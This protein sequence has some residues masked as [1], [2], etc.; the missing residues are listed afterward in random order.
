[1]TPVNI[2]DGSLI[3]NTLFKGEC[4]LRKLGRP[5]RFGSFSLP[6]RKGDCADGHKQ[7]HVKRPLAKMRLNI[8]VNVFFHFRVF[9]GVH[10]WIFTCSLRKIFAALQRRFKSC[11]LVLADYTHSADNVFKENGRKAS[12]GSAENA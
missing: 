4:S 12:E 2:L 3:R 7:K 1:M 9:L 5:A 8:R 6:Q 11:D 10:Y